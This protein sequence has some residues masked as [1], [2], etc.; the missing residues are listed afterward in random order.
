MGS[1]FTRMSLKFTEKLCVM[2][3]KN[4]EKTDMTN[5]VNFNA[6]SGKFENL[7]FDVLLLSIA[8]EVSVKKESFS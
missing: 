5:L 7:P 6:S 8:Y 1:I 3:M 2:T 4:V